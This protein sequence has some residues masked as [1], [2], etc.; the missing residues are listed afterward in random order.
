MTRE[1]IRSKGSLLLSPSLRFCNLKSFM[2]IRD[3][4]VQE[5][6]GSESAPSVLVMKL[7]EWISKGVQETP[8]YARRM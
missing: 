2:I 7:S 1:E 6:L 3:V 5:W 4:E 8:A